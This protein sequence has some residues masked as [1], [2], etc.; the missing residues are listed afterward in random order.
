MQLHI[1]RTRGLL[2]AV[3][4]SQTSPYST[5]GPIRIV[6][7][8]SSTR[9]ICGCGESEKFPFCDGT[10]RRYDGE[11]GTP[12]PLQNS[13]NGEKKISICGCGHT[14]KPPFCDGTHKSLKSN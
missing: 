5:N 12:I 2:F 9:V 8:P 1:M 14:S 10:H 4:G 7:P 13:E 3:R 6:V 11:K